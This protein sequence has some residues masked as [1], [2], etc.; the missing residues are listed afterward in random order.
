[1]AVFEYEV[2]LRATDLLDQLDG[3]HHVEAELA[4]PTHIVHT[5]IALV[6]FSQK[7]LNLLLNIPQPHPMAPFFLPQDL[8]YQITA[9]IEAGRY[10]TSL[11]MQPGSYT[12][13][14]SGQHHHK[15]YRIGMDFV[16]VGFRHCGQSQRYGHVLPVCFYHCWVG[17][18]VDLGG[19]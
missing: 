6:Q 4:Q 9:I 16:T 12:G 1:M 8:V 13:K 18:L 17:K 7:L 11:S 19:D 3:I 15:L 2:H 5:L 14:P 10:D